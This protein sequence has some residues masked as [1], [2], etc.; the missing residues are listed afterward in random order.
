MGCSGNH[1]VAF[2]IKLRELD[3]ETKQ[4]ALAACGLCLFC[5]W[6]PAGAECHGRGRQ[7][8]PACPF[9]KCDEKHS[10]NVNGVF[11]GAS[12][13]VSLVTDEGDE[14]GDDAFANVTRTGEEE[15]EED[16]WQDLDDSWLEMEIWRTKRTMGSSM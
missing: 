11:V 9:P 3:S 5:L 6:Y 1:A 14:Y 4:R 13:S 8:K 7:S 12:A 15:D 2:C 10:A 16:R